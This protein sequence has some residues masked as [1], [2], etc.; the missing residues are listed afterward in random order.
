[1][2]LEYP[3]AYRLRTGSHL[4]NAQ[5]PSRKLEDKNTLSTI[6]HV[7]ILEN[8]KGVKRAKQTT[9]SLPLAFSSQTGNK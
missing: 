3:V 5:K 9:H 8:S 1:M 6:L 2:A 4:C 7:E